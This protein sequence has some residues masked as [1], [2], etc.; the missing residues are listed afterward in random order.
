MITLS[1]V[2]QKK[3]LIDILH[4][5]DNVCRK[6]NIKYTLIGGSLIGAI[7][8]K[9][10]IPWDD[11]IDVGL[12]SDEYDK[13]IDCLKNDNNKKYK[14]LDVYNE[15]TYY[16]PFA[17]L[18]DCDTYGYEDGYKKINGYGVYIDIFKYNNVPD[19]YKEIE[20]YDKKLKKIKRALGRTLR[21][22]SSN[23]IF[24][25]Y[26]KIVSKVNSNKIAKKYI[27]YSEKYNNMN[28]N[29]VMACWTAYKLKNEILPKSYFEK[30][31]DTKFEN[32]KVMIVAEYD[33]VLKN[34]FG[35]YMEL[36]PVDKRVTHHHMTMY[37]KN[38][39][40]K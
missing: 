6:N 13:L 11:D 22:D 25:M 39:N 8:H 2:E 26:R 9:G 5:F 16:Y 20:K 34:V 23:Y 1:D 37:R 15:T 31:I 18:I 28:C 38:D 24:R 17:K 10:I 14:L 40:E 30:Y 36:P 7:R 12:L 19:E 29:K 21:Y 4:Y 3:I 27:N 33:K 35:N 32:I